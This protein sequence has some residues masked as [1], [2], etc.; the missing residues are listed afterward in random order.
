MILIHE[1]A[2]EKAI[3]IAKQYKEHLTRKI[4]SYMKVGTRRYSDKLQCERVAF[5]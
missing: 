4:Y 5:L 3:E 1:I 2:L